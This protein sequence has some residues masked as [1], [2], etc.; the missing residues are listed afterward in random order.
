[1]IS[2]IGG[3]G[4]E[5][6]GLALRFALSG[7]EV[8]LGSRSQERGLEIAS[9][10]KELADIQVQGGTNKQAAQS[11]EIIVVATP[12]DG[13]ME[14]LTSLSDEL[15]GKIIIAVV[16]P[17]TFSNGIISAT[18]VEEGSAAVQAQQILPSSRVVGAFHNI[19]AA[20]LL[21]PSKPIDSDVIVCADDDEA[22]KYVIELSEKIEGIRGID[23][24]RLE[25]SKYSEELTALLLNINKIYKAHSSI[26]I[27]GI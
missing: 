1:M 13:H 17:L 21:V 15:H 5:G 14:T 8:F 19:S 9:S 11:G 2:F 24:G 4:P 25:N 26:R 3:T 20:D 12:Y 10:L 7:E 18:P 16:A 22:K 6:R 23:G 27:T